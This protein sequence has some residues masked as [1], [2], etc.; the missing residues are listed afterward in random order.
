MKCILDGKQAAILV[1]TTVLAQQHYAT[2][3][4]R[5]RSFPVT[6]EVL[7]RF[8]SPKQVKEILERT[9]QGK[10]DLL[11]GTH[12][13]L[14]KNV[15]FHDLGLLIIDEEQRFGVTAKEQLRQRS[16]GHTGYVRH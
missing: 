1:P 16:A 3:V 2:A 5:F 15:S 11:I 8:R 6:V 7:S 14:Q 4:S 13:L 9:A 12:K 10:V